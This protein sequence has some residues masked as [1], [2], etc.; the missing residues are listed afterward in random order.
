LTA[1][2]DKAEFKRRAAKAQVEMAALDVDVLVADNGEL[3][4]WLTGYTVSETMYRAAFLPREGEPWFVLRDLDAGP[5]REQIWFDDIVSF[6]DI[7]SPHSVM[8]E[9][10]IARGFGGAR[11]GVDTNSYGFCVHTANRLKELLPQAIFVPVP[12][13]G[14]RLRRCKSKAE[15][16]VLQQA[17]GIADKAMAAIAEGARPGMTVRA[18]TAVAAGVFL[19]QGADTGEVGPIVKAKGDQEFLHGAFQDDALSEG[20]ILH[21]ELIPKVA[22]YSA[23]MMRPIVLGEPSDERIAIARTLIAIQDRQ[24]AAM[25]AGAW[26]HEVDA[27]MRDGALAAR[28][29]KEYTNVTGY[30]LGLVTRTPRT[31][32]FS[33]VLLPTSVWKLEEGMVFHVYASAQGLAFSETVVVTRDGGVRLTQTPRTF[34]TAGAPAIL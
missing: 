14:Y 1:V 13:V 17:A 27:I 3:L 8:A 19:R 5:C 16:A 2:F 20:D 7:A 22:H 29:R 9:T 15:I 24:I 31:S 11:I 21:V 4:A 18:A 32:D 6:P 26:A 28:L 30:T 10:L 23:R 12:D 34:L 33:Y 25:K